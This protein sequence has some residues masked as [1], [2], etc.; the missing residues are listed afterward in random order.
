MIP[1]IENI[2]D[3]MQGSEYFSVIDL[4]E[5]Y[6][7]IKLAEEDQHK[8]A[9]TIN[10]Q[11]YEWKRTPMGFKN[12]PAIFQRIMERELKEWIYKGCMVYLDDIVMY[13]KTVDEHDDILFKVL[14]KLNEKNFKINAE[15]LQ[16]R[17]KTIKLLGM[18]IDGKTIKM[19][20]EMREK[21][22]EFKIPKTKKDLQRFLGAI[23]Y[24]RRFI[25]EIGKK[26]AMLC[27][28]LRNNKSMADW[29]AEHTKAFQSLQEEA[30]REIVRYHPD[31]TKKFILETDASHNGVGAYLYQLNEK[32]EKEII[33][34][35]ATKLKDSEISWGITE[36]EVYAIV[37][38]LQKLDM[39]LLGRKVKIITD[40][41]AASWIKEKETF[42][43][44]RIQ[45]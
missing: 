44:Y 2:I 34:P 26:T 39:Y 31:S 41:K 38:A 24:H 18:T 4:K 7:Q 43:N 17:K 14:N 45:R 25:D 35:I 10:Q 21:I 33:K 42:G 9:F 3:S 28:I 37:W 1:D 13:A 11:K 36:K 15:K 6:F 40:H 32:G 30:N 8:T 23:T 5:G 12:A 19:P 20:E 29:T 22:M 16:I 27:D